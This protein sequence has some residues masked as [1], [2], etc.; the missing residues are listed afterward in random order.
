MA[1]R[2]NILVTQTG[3]IYPSI[4]AAAKALGVDPSNIGKALSG[5]RKSAGGYNFARIDPSASPSTVT[6]IQEAT[7]QSLSASQKKRQTKLRAQTKIKKAARDKARGQAARMLQGTLKEANRL[8]QEYQSAG[9]S[10][11]SNVIPELEQLQ[12]M[13]GTKKGG[14]F[15]ASFKNLAKF[16]LKELQALNAAITKQLNRKGFKDLKDAAKKKQGVA[17]QLGIYAEELDNY[18]KAIPALWHILQMA[19][20]VQ[21]KGYDRSLYHAA[22][23]AM[24]NQMDPEE[25][26]ALLE[27]IEAAYE[28]YD[29]IEDN[30]DPEQAREDLDREIEEL[31]KSFAD[32]AGELES[33]D[34]W[35]DE[36]EEDDNFI[37]LR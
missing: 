13:I 33:D 3:I 24:Q 26:R 7:E 5:K 19:E 31:V 23:A 25:L 35:N 12:K 29:N 20:N 17:Y 32:Q 15:N 14:G 10:G 2:Y 8:M 1:K 27:D 9:L 6:Q 21:G 37:D 28:R 18:A 4:N 36:D 11:V 16:N 22:Q 34:L 30:D